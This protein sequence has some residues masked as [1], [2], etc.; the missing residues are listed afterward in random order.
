MK[1]LF[2]EIPYLE[3]QR[4]VLRALTEADAIPLQRMKDDPHVYRTLPTFL[5][6]QRYADA[7]EVIRRLYSECRK[8]SIILGVFSNGEFCGLAELYGYREPIHKISVGC[9]LAENWWGKGITTEVIRLLAEYLYSET[10]CEIIAAST[11]I[12]NR[13]AAKAL[14]KNGFD[15][16]AHAAP[17]DWGYPEPLPT[18]KWIR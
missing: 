13:G 10:D 4:I 14:K 5:F 7:G 18:D 2:S 8:E 17:E 3:S 9:R 11:L 1:K 6:E 12:E 16:V 15:L